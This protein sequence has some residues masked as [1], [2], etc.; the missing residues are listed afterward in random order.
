MSETINQ[1]KA[2]INA[3][4]ARVDAY[5]SGVKDENAVIL[6]EEIANLIDGVGEGFV[7]ED[8]YAPDRYYSKIT[9][10]KNIRS[11]YTD[12]EC[13]IEK[14][15]QEFPGV[16]I[17]RDSHG[18]VPVVLV[19]VTSPSGLLVPKFA[20]VKG[21]TYLVKVFYSDKYEAEVDY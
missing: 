10:V 18:N 1:L 5:E 2:Q 13:D 3:L 15:A 21:K 4:Q 14:F 17:T 9:G 6:S 7:S 19:K 12:N 16:P 20:I 8:A 11:S